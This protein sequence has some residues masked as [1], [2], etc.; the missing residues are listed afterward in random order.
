MIR[1]VPR[2]LASL[3]LVAGA[4]VCVAPPAFAQAKKP[5]P[6]KTDPKLAE[7]KK[8]FDDGAA[9]YAQGNYEEAVHAW[10]KAYELSQK[11]LIF[12]SMANA[13][14]RL[15]NAAKA[16]E[17]LAKWRAAAPPEE[18]DLLDA[19]LKNLE[20]RVQREEE[21][22]RKAAEEKAARD[23]QEKAEAEAKKANNKGWLLPGAILAGAGGVLAITGVSIDI[24]AK[25]K[26]PA[27]SACKAAN[28]NT[29]CLDSAADA[30][31][32]SNTLAIVGDA[33]W[34]GGAAAA[35]AG[36]VLIVVLKPKEAK[37]AGPKTAWIA[38]A[39]GGMA[40]GGT[41]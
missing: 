11:P 9:A 22:A 38:P 2:A 7:A 12:E 41:F 36:V 6:A 23:A 34:I 24:A 29:Y 13:Y 5:P 25:G 4:V 28:G 27:S 33:L 32:S 39:P 31:K 35:A 17:Y 40:L 14:E 10:E 26:R 30:I 8:L 19:R 1:H 15:G 21:A 16:R 37:D 20:A 3:A 18:H